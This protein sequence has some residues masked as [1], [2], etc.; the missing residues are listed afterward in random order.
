MRRPVLLFAPLFSGLSCLL[1]LLTCVTSLAEKPNQKLSQVQE[2][3]TKTIRVA[4]YNVAMYRKQSFEL[5]N[6]IETGASKQAKQIA[7]VI[8]RVRPEI[9]LI[10][11]IDYEENSTRL[12]EAFC[13]LYLEKGQNGQ[14]PIRYPYFFYRPVN[15]GVDSGEDLDRDG[16]RGGPADA[17]GFGRYPGQYGMLLLSRFPINEAKSHTFQKVLWKDLPGHHFPIVPTTGES[18]YPK[19]LEAKLRLSSKSFWDV[20][21]EIPSRVRRDAPKS[22]LDSE[23]ALQRTLPMHLLCSHPT[24]PGFDGPEDRNGWRNHDEIGLIARYIDGEANRWGLKDDAGVSCSG[25]LTDQLCV[26]LG[27]LNADP[28]DGGSKPEAI[29]QLL[30]H[31]RLQGKFTPASDGGVAAAAK[32]QKLNANQKGN[33]SHDTANFSQDGY[34]N[35]RADYVIPSKGVQIVDG[36]VFWPRPGEPGAEAIKGSD[37]RLV[38][39]DVKLD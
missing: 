13:K 5:G 30:K 10:N 22:S 1:L 21:V 15:T 6:E 24:P 25:M 26:V 20:C 17:H 38:W 23:G 36:G 19:A 12:P 35:M 14:Q 39:V 8:Q 33:A 4:T 9:L 31:P 3:A 2:A 29:N 18:F 34:A 11:E 16:K 27:D 37:H 28:K 7:E 32:H